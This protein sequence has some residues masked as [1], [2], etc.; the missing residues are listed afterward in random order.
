MSIRT[1]GDPRTKNE[2]NI[3]SSAK[4]A[5][6]EPLRR[7]VLGKIPDP[8][9]EHLPEFVL[10]QARA[11]GRS[12]GQE[13]L[14]RAEMARGEPI[15]Q[16]AT[17][18]SKP[19][20]AE[21]HLGKLAQL[22][23]GGP[24]VGVE[25]H[26][27]S[28]LPN[29]ITF[30]H[31]VSNSIDLSEDYWKRGDFPVS[32]VD[33]KI[34]DKVEKLGKGEFVCDELTPY[35]AKL[36]SSEPERDIR[37]SFDFCKNKPAMVVRYDVTNTSGE[38]KPVELFTSLETSVKTS[39]TYRWLDK[40]W[41]EFDKD[42]GTILTHF[43]DKEAGGAC[44]FVTNAGDPPSSFTTQ[45]ESLHDWSLQGSDRLHDETIPS[46]DLQRPTA[47]YTYAK[48][49]KPGETL[50]VVQIIGSA[51][52]EEVRPL[53]RE[54]RE[55]YPRE[56]D[57]LQKAIVDKVY[58]Q[59]FICTGDKEIDHTTTVAKAIMAT[60][61]HPL[62][63]IPVP[64]P[65]PAQYNFFF[66]HDVLLTDL[67]AVFFDPARVKRDLLYI[68]DHVSEDGIIPHARYVK[69]GQMTTEKVRTDNWNHFWFVL[70]SARYLRHTHDQR[71]LE[72]LYPVLKKSVE[73]MLVNRKDGVICA[74][75]PDWWD[76]GTSFGPRSY[77]TILAIRSLREF[78]YVSSRLGKTGPEAMECEKLAQD[79]QSRLTEKLWDNKLK[80][81]VNYNAKGREDPHLYTGSL[82]AAHFDLLDEEK[83]TAL[84]RTA[85][86]RLVDEDVGVYNAFPMDFH[87]LQKYFDFQEGEAG[88]PFYYMNGGI[89]YHG[90]A[91]YALSLIVNG[92]KDEARDFLKRVMTVDGVMKGPNGQPAMYECRNG[93]KRDQAVYGKVDKPQF[94]W[95]AGWYLYTLYN[96]LGL[97][98]NEWNISFE[99]YVIDKKR[100]AQFEVQIGGIPVSVAGNGTGKYIRSI[101]YDGQAVPSAVVP[102]GMSTLKQ[103]EI[104]LG[105]PECPY[106][107]HADSLVLSSQYDEIDKRLDLRLSAFAGHTNRTKIITPFK[108]R[109]VHLNGET[110][111]AGGWTITKRGAVY[112]VEVPFRHLSDED[113]LSLE[114]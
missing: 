80:Y 36:R 49:L 34:G 31:P 25:I 65:C 20:Y 90:N 63:G 105:R 56:I 95:A 88:E 4:E 39:Y 87:K 11:K 103:I 45:G 96:L 73:E 76:I 50:S 38:S 12:P 42:G 72:K 3:D 57:Q 14:R 69:E 114:F 78:A 109:S 46:S 110:I 60:H 21:G 101:K 77:M 94:L 9:E 67:A 40:A 43:K 53:V 62:D 83:K 8:R 10:S 32:R 81:L 54:I 18:R 91:W 30:F 100:G 2:L 93:N 41:T 7:S 66:T 106:L 70:V 51:T 17:A 47:A 27:G 1:V 15:H 37:V 97:R 74:F 108:P 23:I 98:E 112:E 61:E 111:Q 64:M 5:S 22:E 29:R 68:A 44:L 71:T 58:G 92:R 104:E 48:L 16:L 99:P 79:M 59:G 113:R 33:L 35:S 102:E 84:V 55:T 107:A 24:Y 6:G 26:D 28:I 86:E 89:W 85:K 75:R 82:L 52:E 13:I 19:V